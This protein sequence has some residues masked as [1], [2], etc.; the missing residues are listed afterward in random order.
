V[1]QGPKKRKAR[2][3]DLRRISRSLRD[4]ALATVWERPGRWVTATFGPTDQPPVEILKGWIVES[5][6]AV[7]PKKLVAELDAR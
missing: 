4:F 7:A 2:T 3:G 1:V 5:Y 6:R